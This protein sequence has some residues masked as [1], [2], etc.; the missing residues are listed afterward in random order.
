M[1]NLIEM[2]SYG[3]GSTVSMQKS[4]ASGVPTAVDSEINMK[5][6]YDKSWLMVGKQNS[7]IE[8][9]GEEEE[10]N[11]SQEPPSND[12]R[13]LRPVQ[14]ELLDASLAISCATEEE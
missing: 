5:L 10:P 14:V 12:R 8:D 4:P 13:L 1:V 2:G 9:V 6:V 3:G 7:I 11:E